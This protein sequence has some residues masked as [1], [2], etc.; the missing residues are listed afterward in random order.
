MEQHAIVLTVM[1]IWGLT[2][3]A[4]SASPSLG[5]ATA[6]RLGPVFL[7]P[8]IALRDVGVD[9]NIANDPDH[10]RQDFTLT[11]QPRLRAAMPLGATQLSGALSVGFV[12]YATYKD[13]Q[14]INR[15]YE[16]RFETTTS[17]LRPFVA[18]T[19]SHAR[20][21]AGYEI[22]ARVL[23]RE[24]SLSPGAELRL[25]S[26]TSLYGSYR[27][28]SERYDDEER[29]LGTALAEQ[30]DQASDVATAGARF[31]V[32]PLTT[33][34]VAIERQQDRFEDSPFR[35]SDSLRIM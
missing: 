22:D 33:V 34:S 6:L 20:E 29:F 9:S 15:R 12:Y 32:S 14:S 1:W 3:Q 11:A 7:S 17:R 8:S 19:F 16:G 27:R 10:P 5:E 23:R 30:L 35:D 18:A 13:Q 31:A 2:A 25:T 4:S 21:R 28:T 26:V 24:A